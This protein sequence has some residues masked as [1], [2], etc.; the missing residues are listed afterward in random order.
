MADRLKN[1]VAIVTGASRGIGQAVAERFAKE[2]A[3]V[4]LLSRKIE[5]LE[6]VAGA[7]RAAGGKALAVACHVGREEDIV[8]AVDAVKN[9]FGRVDILVNNAATNPVF[10][11]VMFSDAA[12]FD[13]IFEINVRGPFLL[14]KALLPTFQEHGAGAIV[15]IASTAGIEP[16]PGLGLYSASKSALIGLTRV[17]ADEWAPF[18]VRC[19]VV[20]PGIIKTRFSKALWESEEIMEIALSRQKFKRLG[21]VDDVTGAVLFFAS[22]DSAFITGETLVVDGGAVHG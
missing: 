9:E 14:S 5:A 1:K 10:G 6:P 19:N 20:C 2:G 17:F 8:A 16:M 4:A 22:D 11:P 13:K 3:A 7:I 12:A 21:E 15:N 18:G